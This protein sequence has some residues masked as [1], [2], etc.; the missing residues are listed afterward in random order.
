MLSILKHLILKAGYLLTCY[1]FG[2]GDRHYDNIMITDEGIIF[3]IDYGFIM[4]DEPKK[5]GTFRFA[6]EIKWTSDI[7]QPILSSANINDPFKD[8][9]YEELMIACCEAFHVL[10]SIICLNQIKIMSFV[11]K[12]F[13]I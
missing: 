11:T 1:L 13:L 2:L 5:I 9:A 7:A 4:S 12:C 6:P 3:N 8:K 10:R